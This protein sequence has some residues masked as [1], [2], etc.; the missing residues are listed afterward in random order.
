[1]VAGVLRVRSAR[2]GDQYTVKLAGE[3][4]VATMHHV[5]RELA[6][7]LRS[8]AAVIVLDLR[9]LAFIDCS[10][11]RVIVDAQ[12]RASN[13]LIVKG[14]RRVQRIFEL[15]GLDWPTAFVDRPPQRVVVSAPRASPRTGG[16]RAS[17]RRSTPD[18]RPAAALR[19]DQ[20]VLAA[21]IRDLRS[22]GRRRAP[23]R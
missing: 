8:D 22:C 12:R 1:L 17:A 20:A 14:S 16:A 13:R 5:Q 18:R 4:D 23:L 3:L 6:E 2:A 19:A 9:E 21:A 15:C 7:A 11:L 10:G